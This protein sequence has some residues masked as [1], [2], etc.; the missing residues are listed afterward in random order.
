MGVSKQKKDKKN[1]KN[2]FL[3]C[4]FR[5]LVIRPSLKFLYKFKIEGKEN[6]PQ[7]GPVIFICK[8][9][10]WVDL[11]AV[12]ELTSRQMNYVAKRELFENLFGDFEGS[13]LE[14]IGKAILPMTSGGLWGMG[15][16]PIDREHPEKM[17]SSF[18]Y[19]KELLVQDEFLVFFPEGRT[20]PDIMGEFKKGMIKL[21]LNMNKRA[22]IP[23]TF[24]PVG[25]S[26]SKKDKFRKILQVKIGFPMK[27]DG[28]EIEVLQLIKEKIESL[29]NFS[30]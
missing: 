18:K 26:Y 7:K 5:M 22:E 17:V 6:I 2:F 24:I 3:F 10:S 4:L 21:L 19:I 15:A 8:H 11:F 9:Q 25:I 16:I 23:F 28:N 14:K 13:L 27:F 29:T 20:V 1:R 12:S 30:L